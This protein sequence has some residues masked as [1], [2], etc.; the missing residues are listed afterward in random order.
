MANKAVKRYLA[1]VR[2][3]LVCGAADRKALLARCEAMAEDFCQENPEAEYGAY[4]AAFGEPADF[5]AELLS[6]LDK[7]RVETALKRRRLIRGC[8]AVLL[9][10]IAIS[11]A[12]F[13]YIKYEQ[14]VELNENIEIVEG[15]VVGLVPEMFDSFVE[16]VPETA[17]TYV[18][19]YERENR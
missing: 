16:D 13:W 6:R 17:Q 1:R 12:I 4:V 3:A 7:D 9:A 14:S 10:V 15:T 8:A 18:D 11:C 19:G 5:A 2:R